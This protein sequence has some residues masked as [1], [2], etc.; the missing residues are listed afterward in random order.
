MHEIIKTQDYDRYI[1]TLFTRLN[2]RE[3]IFAVISFNFEL[4]K[5][6]R[7]VS[8]PMIGMI[9]FAWWREA[10]EEAFNLDKQVRNHEIL[11]SLRQLR[12]R[13]GLEATDFI[14]IVDAKQQELGNKAFKNFND[15]KNYVSNTDVL[16]SKIICE[17]TG[18]EDK[19]TIEAALKF[20][21][22]FGIV[23]EIKEAFLNFSNNKFNM[24]ED[25]FLECGAKFE[26]YGKDHFLETSKEAIERIVSYAKNE[27]TEARIILSKVDL[28]TKQKAACP[29]LIGKICDFYIKHIEENDFDI[30]TKPIFNELNPLQIVKL[31]LANFLGK[32]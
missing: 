22:V 25:I 1:T 23:N 28:K 6:L 10:L 12:E 3:D 2:H 18:V 21:L 14:K 17:I 29:L 30:F 26:N 15:F 13:Y 8:E 11:K 20:A 31:S 19:R 4:S 9:R 7:I 24:P 16:I 27:L 5:I 32:Y